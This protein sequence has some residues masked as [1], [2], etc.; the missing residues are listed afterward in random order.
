MTVVRIILGVAVGSCIIAGL[1]AAAVHFPSAAMFLMFGAFGGFILW[2]AYD[3]LR[4]GITGAR[5]SRYERRANPFGFW[6]YILFYGLV[7]ALVL[8][9][10]LYCLLHRAVARQ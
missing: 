2:V 8:G 1:L 4:T 5:R 10:G 3:G 9:Y 6:F 7:G